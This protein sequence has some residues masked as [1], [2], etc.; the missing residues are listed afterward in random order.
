MGNNKYVKAFLRLKSNFETSAFLLEKYIR[1]ADKY[2]GIKYDDDIEDH[3]SKY[4]ENELKHYNKLLCSTIYNDYSALQKISDQKG[5]PY[6]EKQQLKPLYNKLDNLMSK[7]IL[8]EDGKIKVKDFIYR[9]RIRINHP[10][11]PEEEMNFI[12]YYNS[13]ILYHVYDEYLY[14]VINIEEEIIEAIEK[15]IG[16]E[17]IELVKN[18]EMSKKIVNDNYFKIYNKTINNILKSLKKSK[19]K[20]EDCTEIIKKVKS[21]I[22]ESNEKK[23]LDNDGKTIKEMEIL[24]DYLS[25]MS[26][27]YSLIAKNDIKQIGNEEYLISTIFDNN[28]HIVEILL[29]QLHE[30]MI[31]I[32]NDIK[33]SREKML[34][35]LYGKKREIDETTIDYR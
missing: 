13:M 10:E 35:N 23:L 3:K 30:I 14:D 31:K 2:Y 5:N 16:K 32:F 20:K 17:P 19:I 27:K 29:T 11:N 26:E 6:K 18:N 1:V 24:I 7:D 8:F 12:D 22:N 4:L 9:N 25:K 15:D 33:N 34:N 21:T 28:N